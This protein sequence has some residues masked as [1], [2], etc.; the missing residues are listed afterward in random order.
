[1][2]D[3]VS[4]TVVFMTITV[5]VPSTVPEIE[6]QVSHELGVA[7][8]HVDDRQP[9][10]PADHV[11]VDDG[12]PGLVGAPVVDALQ[13]L[14]EGVPGGR[15]VPVGTDKG[16]QSTHGRYLVTGPHPFRGTVRG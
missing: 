3:I 7:V 16:Q 15:R 10:E 9:L 12:H 4:D 5:H 6:S 11:G 8:F 2:E 13:G 1:M 14:G